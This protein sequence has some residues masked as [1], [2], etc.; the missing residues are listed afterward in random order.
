MYFKEVIFIICTEFASALLGFVVDM[1]MQ[2]LEFDCKVYS[3]DI[4]RQHTPIEQRDKV[5]TV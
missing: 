1:M 5:F 3:L 4:S 2:E